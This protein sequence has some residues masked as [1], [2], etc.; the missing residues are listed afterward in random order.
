MLALSEALDLLAMASSVHWY[1]HV[2][3]MLGR[4]VLIHTL[5]FAYR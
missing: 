5:E 2:L 4:H 3:R 1:V